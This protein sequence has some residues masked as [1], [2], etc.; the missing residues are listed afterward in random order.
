MNVFA[1]K[2]GLK[3]NRLDDI[4]KSRAVPVAKNVAFSD[5][6]HTQCGTNGAHRSWTVKASLLLEPHSGM[7][8][9]CETIT[10][11]PMTIKKS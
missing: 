6:C 9:L 1:D 7:H 8:S 4:V 11:S 5:N 3:F 10:H 2:V